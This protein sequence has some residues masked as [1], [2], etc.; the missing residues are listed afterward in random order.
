[1]KDNFAI[2]PVVGTR[3]TPSIIQRMNDAIRRNKIIAGKGVKLS[4]TAGGTIVNAEGASGGIVVGGGGSM[5]FPF[6][7]EP[8]D[9][10]PLV[11]KLDAEGNEVVDENGDTVMVEDTTPDY[12]GYKF[13]LPRNSL[14]INDLDIPFYNFSNCDEG[15][16]DSN[17]WGA[18]K[19]FPEVITKDTV[20]TVMLYI[21]D[22]GY[23]DL[24]VSEDRG[25][26]DGGGGDLFNGDTFQGVA[27]PICYLN[28]WAIGTPENEKTEE[29]AG[30]YVEQFQVGELRIPLAGIGCWEICGDTMINRF[31]L[32]GTQIIHYDDTPYL[33]DIAGDIYDGLIFVSVDSNLAMELRG[34]SIEQYNELAKNPDYCFVPL[35]R[36]LNGNIIAD[37][38]AMPRT[39]AWAYTLNQQ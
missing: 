33:S 18:W 20:G 37:L 1:M 2:N 19:Y 35:Y 11:P 36:V 4:R 23:A 34:A 32:M 25:I 24:I 17:S 30:R 28:K 38:R 3:L 14:L 5:L 29:N 8:Y 39:D 31:V 22:E 15:Y 13:F 10:Y 16:K 7:C 21:N 27:T 9:H 26:D 12:E 6:K